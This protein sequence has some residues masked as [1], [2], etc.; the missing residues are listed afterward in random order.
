[1]QV[2]TSIAFTILAAL[3]GGPVAILA[4]GGFAVYVV[5]QELRERRVR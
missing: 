1:M 3:I 4:M 2:A 5:A